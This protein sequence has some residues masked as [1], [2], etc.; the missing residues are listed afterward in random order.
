M[1]TRTFMSWVAEGLAREAY[2]PEGVAALEDLALRLRHP[3]GL[4]IEILITR[5]R[6]I[7]WPGFRAS[8]FTNPAA[9]LRRHSPSWT[10]L[11]PTETEKPPSIRR[12]TTSG[13]PAEEVCEM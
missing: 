7:R 3:L 12:R 10:L 8:S 9:F 1:R 2:L 5:S 4:A 11:A 13:I 6:C